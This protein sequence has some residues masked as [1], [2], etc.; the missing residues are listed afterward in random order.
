VARNEGVK[1]G[2]AAG[3]DSWATGFIF[4]V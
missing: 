2:G 1:K 3:K 4:G